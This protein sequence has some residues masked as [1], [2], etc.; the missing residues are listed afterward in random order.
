MLDGPSIAPSPSASSRTA[1]LFLFIPKNEV[2]AAIPNSIRN[3]TCDLSLMVFWHVWH[4]L[5]GIKL[6]LTSC[7]VASI[8]VLF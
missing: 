4:V 7:I 5:F 8:Y 2:L 3:S 6:F 1:L